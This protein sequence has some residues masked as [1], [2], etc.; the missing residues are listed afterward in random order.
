MRHLRS[1]SVIS[2]ENYLVGSKL[3]HE[4]GS[5]DVSMVTR[6]MGSPLSYDLTYISNIL[7]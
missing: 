5:L 6:A 2:P 3:P 1:K 4:T 7:P